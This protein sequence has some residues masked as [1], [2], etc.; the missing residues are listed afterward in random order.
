MGKMYVSVA[1]TCNVCNETSTFSATVIVSDNDGK[2]PIIFAKGLRNAAFITINPATQELWATEMGRDYLG[3]NLPPDEIDII[4]DGKDYGWPYCFGD[5]IHDDDFDPANNHSCDNTESP[6]YQIPAHS[7]PL[8]LA[9]INSPQFPSSWQGDLLVAYHGSWNRS[10][11]IGYKVV[12]LKVSGN[13]IT[14]SE[15][16]LTG[17]L[18]DQ[19]VNGPDQALGRPVGLI[20][21]EL[22][23]LYLSDDKAG[24]V[25]IIQNSK[26]TQKSK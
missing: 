24:K 9:F 11:P 5:K 23:N 4:R 25:Y 17:F 7:A 13:S 16:F 3:D 21:D 22:G 14:Q 18:S 10:T 19:A 15:D 8:G 26:M 20:F 12:H 2:N 1:S 6:I